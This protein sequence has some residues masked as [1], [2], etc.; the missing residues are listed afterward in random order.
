[1]KTN[2]PPCKP[3][4]SF[5]HGPTCRFCARRCSKP[6]FPLFFCSFSLSHKA[7]DFLFRW[8]DEGRGGG[9]LCCVTTHADYMMWEEGEQGPS[10]F[11]FV[12]FLL[13]FFLKANQ[14]RPPPPPLVFCQVNP[15]MYS[16]ARLRVSD[17]PVKSNQRR[18]GGGAG[19]GVQAM[20]AQT[21][22]Q[23][24]G[25]QGTRQ[26]FPPAAFRGPGGCDG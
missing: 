25:T 8:D 16:L 6:V 9:G 1:M 4:P 26:L 19:G 21:Q 7:D 13:F 24:Q 22:T 2:A 3:P 20:Q 14:A 10:F 17:V 11:H 15:Y 18:T 5:C 12:R 23:A